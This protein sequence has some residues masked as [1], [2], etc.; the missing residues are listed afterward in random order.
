M[1]KTGE[2]SNWQDTESWLYY[3]YGKEVAVGT[4]LGQLQLVVRTGLE[5]EWGAGPRILRV[6]PH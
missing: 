6:Q 2:K 1:V 3:R 4:T 5:S